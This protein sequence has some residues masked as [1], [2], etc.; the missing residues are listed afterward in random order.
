MKQIKIALVSVGSLNYPVDFS[1]LERWSSDLMTIHHVASIGFIP[2]ARGYNWE[3][4]DSQLASIIK[5]E[6]DSDFTLAI[7]NARL[8]NNYYMRR[9]NENVGVLSLYE[10]ADIIRTANFTLEDFILRNLY[11]L[12]VLF[13]AHHGKKLSKDVYSWAHDETRGCLFDMNANKTDIVFSMHKPVL[14]NSC[15][16][17]LLAKQVDSK[18]IPTLDVELPKIRRALF[19]RIQM[20][21]KKHPIWSLVLA[22]G[23]SVILNLIAS[24]IFEIGKVY[25][26]KLD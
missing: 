12:V 23:A 20:W 11:E 4:P 2:D 1:A 18:V 10:M 5:I 8:E 25:F 22:G 14:C 21:V 7:I 13:V 24:I 17:R 9:L 15:R 3:Y 16:T 26:T 19:F 6:P